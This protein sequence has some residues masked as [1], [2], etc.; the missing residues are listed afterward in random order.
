MSSFDKNIWRLPK[1]A[2]PGSLG[3]PQRRAQNEIVLSEQSKQTFT[4]QQSKQAAWRHFL[5][6]QDL[7]A[8]QHG[9]QKWKSRQIPRAKRGDAH[10]GGAS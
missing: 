10:D 7:T 4:K 1:I 9:K 3:G 6:S 2:T 5:S 8:K